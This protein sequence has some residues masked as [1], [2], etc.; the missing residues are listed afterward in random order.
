MKKLIKQEIKMHTS[1]MSCKQIAI[2]LNQKKNTVLVN[3]RNHQCLRPNTGRLAEDLVENYL[4]KNNLPYERQ[5]GD[6][7]YDF[8]IN[9]KKI[10][11][12]S[13]NEVAGRYA[14]E[15]S[16]DKNRLERKIISESCDYLYLVFLDKDKKPCYILDTKEINPIKTLHVSNPDYYRGKYNLRFKFFLD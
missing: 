6:S 10:D 11:V 7:P 1:G 9:S 4:I 2:K 5:K 8:L 13:A 16:S 14:F 3:L 15:L 12:K